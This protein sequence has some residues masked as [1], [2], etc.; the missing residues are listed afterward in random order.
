MKLKKGCLKVA[1][2]LSSKKKWPTLRNVS[3]GFS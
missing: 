3:R 2:L 1:G